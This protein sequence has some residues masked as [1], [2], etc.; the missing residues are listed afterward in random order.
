M[1]VRR[2]VS[3]VSVSLF[4]MLTS[5]AATTLEASWTRPE[6]AGQR[7]AGPVLV[8]AL[9]RD[10]TVRRI[11]E[12]DMA[13]KLAARGVPA[14]RSYEAVPGALTKADTERLLAAAQKAGAQYVLSTALIAQETEQVVTQE[15][16]GYV[17]G[18]YGGWYGS[19]WGPAYTE[20]R[21][22]NIYIAQTSLV[23]VAADRVEWAARTRTTAPSNIDRDT[24]EFVDVIL[25]A[26]TEAKLVAAAK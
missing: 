3:F 22:Y 5:C 8:V 25:G 11:Y 26:M 21:T 10:D 4:L 23:A 9:A 13:A 17:G 2:F 15:S 19:Q 14:L 6:F 24:R 12:D 16:V 7:V 18:G 20:V 1:S